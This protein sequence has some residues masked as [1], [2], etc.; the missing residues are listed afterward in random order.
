[1]F[2]NTQSAES[3]LRT[4]NFSGG[5]HTSASRPGFNSKLPGTARHYPHLFASM[6]VCFVIDSLGSGGAERSTAVML[7]Y[8]R[9]R[10]VDP[11]VIVLYAAEGNEDA[12]R[13]AGFDLQVLQSARLIA[14]VRE[15]R[16]VIKAERPDILHT[17]LFASD[18]IGRLAAVGT[19]TK[20]VSSL[21]STPRRSARTSTG[22]G[23]ARWKIRVVNAIDIVTSHLFVDRFHAVS[24]GVATAFRTKYR[25]PAR[26]LS[27]VERGRQATELGEKSDERRAL[28]RQELGIDSSAEVVL[29]VG[30]HDY[31][32]AHTDLIRAI[33]QLTASRP[34]IT[35][36]VAGREGPST[37][38]IKAEIEAIDGLR[39][40]VR[41]LGYRADIADLL[42][43]S[44]VMTLPSLLEG[45]AGVALEAMAVGTPIVSTRLDGLEGILIDEQNALVVPIGDPPAMAAA[46]AR[47]L[48]D[49]ELATR[50]AEA[51]RKDFL[52]RF[53]IERAADGMVA[54]YRDVVAS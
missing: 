5:R 2:T 12:V 10:G 25:L 3:T 49:R 50:L 18:Q 37:A 22:I 42:A 31:V 33:S 13:D 38:D 40:H 41:L 21:V 16:H 26:N 43:A 6:R 39:N 35:L 44:D 51:G 45:T 14:R 30:R 11:S 29:A 20:V 27:V 9:E 1:M 54:M 47:L 4:P 46:I 32:K 19:R 36:L 23:P 34:K 52:E 48:D 24:Q 17:T 15:L 28:V 53:T 8:L 7:P